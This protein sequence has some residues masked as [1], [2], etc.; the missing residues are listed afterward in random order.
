M[1][2]ITPFLFSASKSLDLEKSGD[3]YCW[4]ENG[5]VIISLILRDILRSR[6]ELQGIRHSGFSSGV[7]FMEA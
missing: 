5:N 3:L 7:H 6:K 4:I 1:I 2:K